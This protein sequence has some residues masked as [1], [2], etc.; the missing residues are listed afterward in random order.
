MLSKPGFN[1][2]QAVDKNTAYA[3]LTEANCSVE[4]RKIEEKCRREQNKMYTIQYLYSSI[5]SGL[6]CGCQGLCACV[7]GNSNISLNKK[8]KPMTLYYP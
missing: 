3:I 6:C 8:A 5:E 7:C 1:F 2:K 4:D